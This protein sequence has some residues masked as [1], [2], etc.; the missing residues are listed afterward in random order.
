MLLGSNKPGV[1][2]EH[3]ALSFTESLSY[4]LVRFEMGLT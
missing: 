4:Q 1:L 2:E 3:L